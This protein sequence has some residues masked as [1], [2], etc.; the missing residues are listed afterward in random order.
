MPHVKAIFWKRVSV[1]PQA[2]QEHKRGP[3]GSHAVFYNSLR[4][5]A[6]SFLWIAVT[7]LGI[8]TWR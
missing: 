8:D 4:S 1:H 5:Q 6:A 2:A 7:L 3:G